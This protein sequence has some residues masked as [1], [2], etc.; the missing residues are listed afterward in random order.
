V[1]RRREDP[2]YPFAGIYAPGDFLIT[3]ETARAA[4]FDI[5]TSGGFLRSDRNLTNGQRNRVHELVVGKSIALGDYYADVPPMQTAEMSTWSPYLDWP[6]HSSSETATQGILVG[7]AFVLTLL[8]V[9][10]GLALA[11]AEGVAERDVLVAVGGRPRTMRSMA[12]VKAVV[13]TVTGLGLAV[14]FGLLPTYAVLRATERPF[15]VPWLVLGALV[16][17]VPLVAGA[18]TWIVSAIGQ[19]I[20]PVRISTLAFD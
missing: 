2:S 15:H 8:V 17:G 13:L 4:G 11:A 18:V 7:V 14:P 20:R 9:A 5:V 6:D 12:A 1:R 19:A 3:E 16:V 10:I